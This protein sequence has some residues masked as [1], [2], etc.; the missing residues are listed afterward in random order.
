MRGFIGDLRD[1]DWSRKDI[2]AVRSRRER[3]SFPG[4]PHLP[5]GPQLER[6]Q[7]AV[8]EVGR[9]DAAGDCDGVDILDGA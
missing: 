4:K 5:A 2:A 6:Q 8:D 1:V 7:G 9:G 3:A